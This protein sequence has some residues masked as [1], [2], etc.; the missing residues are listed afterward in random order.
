MHY[1]FGRYAFSTNAGL[2]LEGQ[3]IHL[4]PKARRL[5]ELLLDADGA[6]VGKDR[7]VATLWNGGEVTDDSISRAAYRLRSAMQQAG[8]PDLIATVYGVGFRLA[9]SVRASQGKRPTTAHAQARSGNSSAI[10]AL[11]SARELAAR[12]TPADLEAAAAAAK[13]AL[14]L[15]PGFVAAWCALAEIR[16]LQVGRAFLPP[17]EAGPLIVDAAHNALALDPDCA[18]AL[19]ARGWV[20]AIIDRRVAAGLTELDRAL[21]IDPQ[22]WGTH[23]LRAWVLQ[24]ARRLDEA[25]D[26]LRAAV[27]VNSVGPSIGGMLPLYLLFAGHRD[28]ALAT[29]RELAS[30]SP[31]I[32]D[33][34]VA[35]CTMASMHG[36]HGEAIDFGRRAMALAPHTPLMH[37]PLA[38][39][40]A[41]AGHADEARSLL[42]TIEAQPHSSPA[43]TARVHVALGNRAT[44]IAQLVS[45]FE[46]RLPQFVWSRDDPRFEP[47]RGEPVLERL[48]AQIAPATR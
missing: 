47:L 8:G 46:S 26:M 41:R 30:Q 40:L 37:V 13:V 31:T 3:P 15:D 23:L 39:A 4:M 32:D 10:W 19:A 9:V 14:Q 38:Y 48:W 22:F 20:T 1:E 29:A 17:R 27:R 5:L 25:I 35:V 34:Q 36:L 21:A 16:L 24:A 44:A 28:E 33:A 43:A 42:A 45:S 18:A 6:V 11:I 7:L 12:H 2:T